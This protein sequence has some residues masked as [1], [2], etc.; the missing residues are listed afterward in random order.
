[1]TDQSADFKT[2]RSIVKYALQPALMFGVLF[3]WSLYP[4][5]PAVYPL[6]I[7]SVQLVLGGLESWLPARSHWRQIGWE[8]VLNVCLVLL[9]T[10]GVVTV[11]GFYAELLA[12]PLSNLRQDLGLDIWPHEWP[13]LVQLFMAFFLSEFIWYWFHRAEHRWAVI[14]RVSGHGAHHAFKKLEAINFGLN[15]PLEFSLL[16]LPSAL[17]EL[18]FGVGLAAAG[19]GF[20]VVTLASIAHSNL[21]LNTKVIGWL[22]TTNDYHIR[23]HSV[24]LEESNTNYGCSAIIW[25]RVFGTFVDSNIVEVGTGASEPSLWQKF[26]MPIRQPTDTAIAP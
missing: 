19:A 17:V 22:F 16:V 5:S 3:V 24:V 26:I 25:D 2:V 6:I 14:W 18:F 20:L 15:H 11:G 13:V 10:I 23:H 12:Q 7:L 21:D 4:D 9:L 8:K 1:M